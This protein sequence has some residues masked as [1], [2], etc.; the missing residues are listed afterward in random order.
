MFYSLFP[1]WV[2]V[3]ITCVV[4]IIRD[5]SENFK[6]GGG[7][8]IFTCEIWVSLDWQNVGAPPP[9]H[10]DWQNLATLHFFFNLYVCSMALF[11]LFLVPYLESFTH[12]CIVIITVCVSVST[13]FSKSLRIW[14]EPWFPIYHI[15]LYGQRKFI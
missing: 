11:E 7:I 5:S 4:S 9:S 15:I 6:R 14:D 12:V 1:D 10:E 8:L 13:F 2:S 3:I